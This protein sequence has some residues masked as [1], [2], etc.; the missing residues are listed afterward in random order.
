MWLKARPSCSTSRGILSASLK[1]GDTTLSFIIA[2]RRGNRSLI[3]TGCVLLVRPSLRGRKLAGRNP[4]QLEPSEPRN[5]TLPC[6]QKSGLA[7]RLA[8]ADFDVA[9]R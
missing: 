4:V 3:E 6:V 7:R 8:L 1:V 9:E 2:L 5:R